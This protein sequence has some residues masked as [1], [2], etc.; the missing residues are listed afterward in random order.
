[1]PDLYD[2]NFEGYIFCVPP[3]LAPI[4]AFLG[5]LLLTGGMLDQSP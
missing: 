5:P 4:L 1:M 2:R 3:T